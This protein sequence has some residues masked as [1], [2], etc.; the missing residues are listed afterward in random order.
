MIGCSGLLGPVGIKVCIKPGNSSIGDDD[1]EVQTALRN[2]Q[3]KT[4]P[5]I[6]SPRYSLTA[7]I[8]RKDFDLR[9]KHDFSYIHTYMKTRLPYAS[10]SCQLEKQLFHG[11]SHGVTHNPLLLLL[12]CA[13]WCM[14]PMV[15]SIWNALVFPGCPDQHH[16]EAGPT[17]TSTNNT[18]IQ[19]Y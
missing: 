14:C 19:A 8:F 15:C 10:L 9:G 13:A 18:K 12:C 11:V 3:V 6:P 4:P 5:K 1:N 2:F 17:P 7:Y 16:S